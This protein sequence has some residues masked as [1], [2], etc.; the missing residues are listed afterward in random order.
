M[1]IE[2]LGGGARTAFIDIVGRRAGANGL[3]D[4]GGRRK[5]RLADPVS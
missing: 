2:A 1:I 3:R 4:D 5:T